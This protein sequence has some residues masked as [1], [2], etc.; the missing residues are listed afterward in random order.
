MLDAGLKGRKELNVRNSL[1]ILQEHSSESQKENQPE[2]F[3][4]I[5]LFLSE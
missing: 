1:K 3:S 2:N 5:L 4:E